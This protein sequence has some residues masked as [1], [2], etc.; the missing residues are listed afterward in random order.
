MISQ[1]FHRI[2]ESDKAQLAPLGLRFA[3]V[4]FFLLLTVVAAPLLGFEFLLFPIS[5]LCLA[6]LAVNGVFLLWVIKGRWLRFRVY[7]STFFD[8]ILT[9]FA[10]H[11]LG[12]IETPFFWV[13]ALILAAVATLHGV[14]IGVYAAT[15]STIMYAGLLLGEFFHIIP[16]VDFQRLNPAYLHEDAS[17][18]VVVLLSNSTLF[19]LIAG[20]SG[21]LSERL[22]RSRNML[23]RAG[24]A[25]Q[26]ENVDRKQLEQSLR[27]SEAKYRKLME[28]A[29]DAI[30]VADADTGEILEANKRA[31][32]M[33]GLLP[34]QIV[35]MHQTLL[36]PPREAE[37]YADL[38]R[39][40]VEAGAGILDEPDVHICH[41]SGRQIPVEISGSVIDLGGRRVIQGIFHGLTERRRM[42]NELRE[43]RDRLE[44]LVKERTQ[45]LAEVNRMLRSEV[46]VR[47]RAEEELRQSEEKYRTLVEN[48][49]DHVLLLDQEGMI[50]YINFSKEFSSRVEVIGRKASGL[51]QEESAKIYEKT[52][53][54]TVESKMPSGLEIV[55]A[56]GKTYRVRLIPLG[57]KIMSVGTD[58]TERKL[59]E[60]AL[61]KSEQKYRSLVDLTSDSVYELDEKLRYT[62]VSGRGGDISGRKPEDHIGKTPFDYMPEEERERVLGFLQDKLVAPQPLRAFEN[63]LVGQDGRPVVVE[64]SAV[65]I[66]GAQG[67]FSGYLCVDRDITE[68]KRAEEALRES[69]ERWRSLVEN[70]PDTVLT[71]D[72]KGKILFINRPIAGIDA[73]DAV[74]TSVL[75]YVVPEYRERVSRA[76][77]R[78]FQTG[79]SDSYEIV[80]RGPSNALSWYATNLAPIKF[81]GKVQSAIMITRDINESKSVEFQL[82]QREAHLQSI[83]E[84]SL[85]GIAVTSEQQRVVYGNSALAHMFGYDKSSDVIDTETIN[86]F[87]PES[88]P[89]LQALRER[90]GNQEPIDAVV[91]F[92]GKR[93]NGSAFDAEMKINFFF[94]GG[95]RLDVAAIRDVTERKK[96]EH[97]LRQAGKL[98]AVGEL[99]AGVAHE[100]N[101]PIAAIDVQTGLLRDI[102]EEERENLREHFL[103]RIE[104]YFGTVE[105]LVQRCQSVTS[106]LLSFTRIPQYRE[107]AVDLNKLLRQTLDLVVGLTDKN[108]E[109]ALLLDERLPLLSCDPHQLQQVFINL[110]NNAL[111]AIDSGGTITVA[112]RLNEDG[113]IGIQFEDSGCGIPVETQ[114]RIFDPF[115]TTRPEGTGI[116]LSISHYT[117]EQM[118][119]KISVRS[120]PGKGSTFTVTLPASSGTMESPEGASI[121]E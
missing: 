85:D 36:H 68:R 45:E 5:V 90:L 88:Y 83:L 48:M 107:D 84:T 104:T 79:Q 62:Y 20:V 54:R 119:G 72:R 102:V 31:G 92:K 67:E 61:H 82:R 91:E 108:P 16:H 44:E 78:V 69:E 4:A 24:E 115:F 7:I 9:T 80:A 114:E 59:A 121:P 42:E 10:M 60:E 76:I 43:H 56:F 55:S 35:G 95:Q 13:Y 53:Q 23:K 47:R 6:A 103:N 94:D 51:M 2:R 97:Q 26:R 81:N 74:G 37:R 101:N 65:P 34:E 14:R 32:E 118:N 40:S 120:A 39:R 96:M 98:A 116:G 8:L 113:S 12:G 75:D 73:E 41:K 70:A 1:F 15:V 99:A 21:L 63:I 86:Y 71:V 111:N 57:D 17:Y 87:A 58:I 22:L 109:V 11:Y 27:D 28:T 19:F 105:G 29:N 100:I 25:L 110:L 38:F 106:S 50:L 117:I 89:V 112:S 46:D 18:L 33:M 66:Y 3:L 64:T 30:L 52:L 49:P 77:Q 93:K